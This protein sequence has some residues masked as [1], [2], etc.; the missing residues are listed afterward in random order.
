LIRQELEGND[1]DALI[2]VDRYGIDECLASGAL[3]AVFRGYDPVLHRPVAIKILRSE[4]ARDGGAEGLHERFKRRA[5]AAGRLFHPNIPTTFDFGEDNGIP[6]AVMEYVDGSPLD[7]LLK[8]AGPFAP[9]RAVAILLQV[10][11]ALKYSYENRVIHLDLKPSIVL[12]LGNNQVKVADFGIALVNA[13]EPTRISEALPTTSSVAPEQL[14]GAPVDHWTDLFSAG[15]LLF[16][17]LTCTRP[18]RGGSV[19][20]TLTQMENRGP[21]NVCAL[22][23]EV[24]RALRSVIEKALAY[25]PGQRFATA[26]AFSYAVSEAV[27]LG[28]GT[29]IVM[30]SLASQTA[31]QEHSAAENK[32]RWDPEILHRVEAD[33]ATHIGPVAAIAVKRAAKQ[34][35]DLIALYEE[36]S[37][38]V[39]NDKE[40][41]E[42]LAS[43]RR[44]TT[45]RPR[46]LAFPHP[47]N[48]ASDS[49]VQRS[50]P[51]DPPDLAVL[52]IIEA[53]LAKYLGPI[54]QPLLQ[55]RLQNFQGFSDLCRSLADHISDESERAAFLDLALT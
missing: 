22:N 23:P 51:L 41:G 13:S 40:R 49:I 29:G 44:V 35:N 33:L 21:E 18:F 34:A 7:R 38:Y 28:D 5:R 30:R 45:A 25:D 42:F 43:E 11:D 36:L 12:V 1:V 2:S 47:D 37:V 54:A 16:Q 15:A 8:I 9:Q 48:G 32:N 19:A 53:R 6:F 26:G 50:R 3:G 14:M 55:Q 10:L 39:R 46:R 20:E 4:L 31:S 52:N 27:S 24:P 17:M